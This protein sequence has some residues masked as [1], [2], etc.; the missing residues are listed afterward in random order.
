MRPSTIARYTR[1]HGDAAL[2]VAYPDPSVI[3]YIMRNTP[4]T[5]LQRMLQAQDEQGNTVLHLVVTETDN[6]T[7]TQALMDHGA[8]CN[9]HNANGMTP[10]HLALKCCVHPPHGD[11]T[12]T[13]V[14]VLLDSGRVSHAY[15]QHSDNNRRNC[16]MYAVRHGTVGLVRQLLQQGCDPSAETD[17][18]SNNALHMACSMNRIDIPDIISTVLESRP[19][20]NERISILSQPNSDRWTPLMLANCNPYEPV[21][22]RVA[23]FRQRLNI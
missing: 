8:N 2:L 20:D 13:P 4:Q 1:Q 10:L 12:R 11:E 23:A 19:N 22:S 15:E 5:A 17:L 7:I 21:R 14:N 16:V 3:R 18:E 9:A 6:T